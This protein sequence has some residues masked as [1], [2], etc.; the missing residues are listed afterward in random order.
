MVHVKGSRDCGNSPKNT[1]SQTIGV[2]I[3]SGEFLEEAFA[4]DMIWEQ[5]GGETIGSEAVKA[6]LAEVD[7]PVS[8]VV[9]HAITH[10]RA[11]ATSGLA[12]LPDGKTRR[13][14]HVIEFTNTKANKVAKIKSYV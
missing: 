11:G 1:F 6:A 8:I 13:Y 3:E 12:T 10:G 5:Q 7:Q 9:E 2:A 4:D 14:S